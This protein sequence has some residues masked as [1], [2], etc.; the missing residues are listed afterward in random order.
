MDRPYIFYPY[1][2]VNIV[3]HAHFLPCAWPLHTHPHLHLPLDSVSICGGNTVCDRPP[4][5]SFLHVST[6]FSEEFPWP[7]DPSSPTCECVIQLLSGMDAAVLEQSGFWNHNSVGSLTW[8]ALV[9][10]PSSPGASHGLFKFCPRYFQCAR[11][12][13]SLSSVSNL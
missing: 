6:P 11:P 10:A 1:C 7:T 9:T 13:P 3:V 5:L 2:L 4:L 8:T 12:R